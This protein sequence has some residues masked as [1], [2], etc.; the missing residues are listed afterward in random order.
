M[1]QIFELTK[2]MDE[3][4]LEVFGRISAGAATCDVEDASTTAGSDA[5]SICPSS[6]ESN[7]EALQLVVKGTFLHMV[8]P[9]EAQK[10]S[11]S[12]PASK[13]ST[14]APAGSLEESAEQA[15]LEDEGMCCQLEV[16]RTFVHIVRRPE[17]RR[18]LRSADRFCTN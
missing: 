7:D 11:R 5:A 18:R 4:A 15:A 1:T 9:Q 17:N 2:F 13:F 8:R 3:T 10:R 6:S 12:A 14:S 16:R